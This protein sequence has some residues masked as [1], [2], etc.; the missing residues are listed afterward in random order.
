M[1][2]LLCQVNFKIQDHFQD[3]EPQTNELPL[4]GQIVNQLL[5]LAIF[6]LSLSV[7]VAA[8]LFIYSTGN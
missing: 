5:I 4:S 2:P 7:Q 6:S 8:V 1:A 3:K